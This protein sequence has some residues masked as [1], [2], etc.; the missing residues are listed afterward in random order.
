MKQSQELQK[1]APP[2]KQWVIPPAKRSKSTSLDVPFWPGITQMV[3]I[4]EKH[5]IP[6][7]G[8]SAV[9]FKLVLTPPPFPRLTDA[10]ETSFV[11]RKV[12]KPVA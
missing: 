10:W 6:A 2:Q 9:I 5:W 8:S 3:Y 4:P 11:T 1:S 7:S 12:W